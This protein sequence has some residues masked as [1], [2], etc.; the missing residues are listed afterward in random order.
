MMP[1]RL[2]LCL[3]I[4]LKENINQNAW[5]ATS[6]LLINYNILLFEALEKLAAI[7][8]LHGLITCTNIKVS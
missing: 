8:S 1:V 7:G 5:V 2:A 3:V 6:P 4:Y